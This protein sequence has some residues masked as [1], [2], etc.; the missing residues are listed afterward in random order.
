MIHLTYFFLLIPGEY[1]GTKY[2]TPTFQ[3]KDV[4]LICGAAN[5]GIFQKPLDDLKITLMVR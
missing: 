2:P 1:T 5:F 4:S 3:L